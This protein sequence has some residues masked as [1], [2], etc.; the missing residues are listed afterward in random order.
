M[1]SPSSALLSPSLV[2]ER[3]RWFSLEQD[4]DA[5]RSIEEL[6]SVAARIPLALASPELH[7]VQ[8]DLLL[9]AWP[10]LPSPR[11]PPWHLAALPALCRLSWARLSLLVEPGRYGEVLDNSLPWHLLLEGLDVL[12]AP[13]PM[14]TLRALLATGEPTPGEHALEALRSVVTQGHASAD[15]AHRLLLELL[16]SPASWLQE[17]S[18]RALASPWA[19]VFSIPERLLDAGLQSGVDAV[20]LAAAEAAGIRGLAPALAWLSSPS[21]ERRRSAVRWA[22]RL[23]DE[24]HLDPLLEAALQDPAGLGP[25]VLQALIELHHRGVF[26]KGD[27]AL[28][29]LEL[30]AL[31]VPCAPESAAGLLF[32]ARRGL[33]E[34]F[35]AL[36][37]DDPD[38]L[39]LAPLIAAW[40]R[41]PRPPRGLF[42]LLLRVARGAR[43]P[44]VLS[45]ALRLLRSLAI[46][47]H[48]APL[49]AIESLALA[50]LRDASVECME[51]LHAVGGEETRRWLESSPD[52]LEEGRFRL[53]WQLT[54]GGERGPL[55]A[56]ARPA[57]LTGKVRG[58]LAPEM[59]EEAR[60]RLWLGG[61]TEELSSSLIALTRVATPASLPTLRQGLRSALVEAVAQPR[62][63]AAPEPDGDRVGGEER[64]Q[65]P[66]PCVQAFEAMEARWRLRHERPR[67]L[68]AP[69]RRLLPELLLELLR[70]DP[71]DALRAGILRTLLALEPH[72]LLPACGAEALGSKDP[73]TAKLGAR[74]LARGGAPWLATELR[75]G[76]EGG[77]ERTL[78]ACLEALAASKLPAAVPVALACLEHRTMNLKKAGAAAL[79]RVPAPQASAAIVGWLGRHD[80]PGLRASLG[81]ALEQALGEG[82][83]AALLGALRE[84]GGDERRCRLLIGA[85][86]AVPVGLVR[87]LVRHQHPW[88]RWLLEALVRGEISLLGGVISDLDPELRAA[89]LAPALP[90]EPDATEP[91]EGPDPFQLA[92]DALYFEGWSPERV[93]AA[94]A[95]WPRALEAAHVEKLRTF[96]G[97]WLSWIQVHRDPRA[98]PLLQAILRAPGAAELELIGRARAGLLAAFEESPRGRRAELFPL[99][100]A[101]L[102]GMDSA[103]RLEL[104]E[105]VRRHLDGLPGLARSPLGM[106]QGCGLVLS[107]V[108]VE[109]ALDGVG[110]VRNPAE[111]R[112]QILADAFGSPARPS[113]PAALSK[114]QVAA[115]TDALRAHGP[116]P[117]QALQGTISPEQRRAAL[118]WLIQEL[119]AAWP[120]PAVR[121]AGLDWMEQLQPIGVTGWFP[122]PPGRP[123]PRAHRPPGLRPH[124]ARLDLFSSWLR[125]EQGPSDLDLRGVALAL[126]P[127]ELEG[128][129]ARAETGRLENL[130]GVLRDQDRGPLAALLLAL[131]ERWEQL[132][133]ATQQALRDRRQRLEAPGTGPLEPA[134]RRALQEARARLWT[135]PR[136]V[137][138][139]SF[140]AAEDGQRAAWLAAARG[141]DVNAAREA[142]SRLAERPEEGWRALVL[143]RAEHGPPRV[144]HH[145]LRLIR[146]TLPPE[147]ALLAAR[148]FLDDPAPAS[149]RMA[150]RSLCHG[151]DLP[152]LPRVV[153]LL[154]DPTAWVREEALRGLLLLREDAIPWVERARARARPDEARRLEAALLRL[155]G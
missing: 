31:G 55:L 10:W 57:W 145:A 80:N 59:P 151:K 2:E 36:A 56:R 65:L 144:R 143:E 89:S 24:R 96:L 152:S 135:A 63:P 53:L 88:S 23:G 106:L 99:L 69:G 107:R 47:R 86:G 66:A 9:R 50:R 13:G 29:V 150:I 139:R 123:A 73:D 18:F 41:S 28:S 136:A 52:P 64:W 54:P 60:D 62:A 71:P 142:L 70:E 74:L 44:A 39:H 35:S 46:D 37:P 48:D 141:K 83:R 7:A 104:G 43:R 146:K 114:E 121:K 108:D 101:L 8:C 111:V 148:S 147:D 126:T 140:H 138:A 137:P 34:V 17:A 100:E 102:L 91:A 117:L 98:V 76:A 118:R 87:R 130:L 110:A 112:R 33:V 153:A 131:Q 68:L 105:L 94:L 15:E 19:S 72:P 82:A 95:R 84:A 125:G 3:S 78:R 45:L 92:V 67:C 21:L 155:R 14:A 42:E 32:V 93:Q 133:R 81:K 128:A 124:E 120:T 27:R 77:E 16:A 4:L 134:D 116:G 75:R 119:P 122:E 20:A 1:S 154:L 51:L 58:S 49:A 25:L 11:L 97:A 129:L 30:L 132:S 6:R 61:G 115:L 22:G 149:R 40:L 85:L 90:A 26:L 38:W 113:P 5:A 109:R 127:E 103:A 12:R 79:E